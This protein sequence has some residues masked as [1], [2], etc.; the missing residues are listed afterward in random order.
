MYWNVPR[1]V[2]CC[3]IARGISVGSDVA[4]D[5]DFTAGAAVFARPKSRSFTPDFVSMTFPGFRSRWMMPAWCAASRAAAISIDIFRSCS[6]GSGP[7][8]Q[9]LGERLS[10]E[11]AP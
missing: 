10:L 9:P 11:R 7:P 2:P 8:E 6:G 5:D 4:E 3:V 1:I